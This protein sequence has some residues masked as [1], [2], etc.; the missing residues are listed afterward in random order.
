MPQG[1]PQSP[2]IKGTDDNRCPFHKSQ[3]EAIHDINKMLARQQ[4]VFFDN[5]VRQKTE[6]LEDQERLKELFR[7]ICK[8][9]EAQLG[10]YCACQSKQVRSNRGSRYKKQEKEEL[11]ALYKKHGADLNQIFIEYNEKFPHRSKPSMRNCIK[12]MMEKEQDALEAR[13]LVSEQD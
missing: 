10:R 11:A 3:E 13:D 2:E 4:Q 9:G 5:Q 12:K 7:E 8:H 1:T 6:F